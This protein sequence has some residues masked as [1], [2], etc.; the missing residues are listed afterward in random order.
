VS[1]DRITNEV[2]YEEIKE[3]RKEVGD[4]KVEIA[5]LKVKSGMWGAIGGLLVALPLVMAVINLV[6]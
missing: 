1:P 3:V 4:I 6:G 5:V 2:L